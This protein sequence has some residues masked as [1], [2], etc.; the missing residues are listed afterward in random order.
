MSECCVLCIVCCALCFV[1]CVL[2]C[3]VCYVLREGRDVSLGGK[4]IVDLDGLLFMFP[5]PANVGVGSTE[6]E[7]FGKDEGIDLSVEADRNISAYVLHAAKPAAR[8]SL[9]PR[10]PRPTPAT[11]KR[12]QG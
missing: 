11:Q 6:A 5:P 9:I 2:L 1:G 10:L 7:P 4:V 12:T 3:V 8:G